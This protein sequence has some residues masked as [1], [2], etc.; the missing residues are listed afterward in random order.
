MGDMSNPHT[1]AVETDNALA[2]LYGRIEQSLVK[3][4]W[5][6]DTIR[7]AAGQERVSTSRTRG[8]WAVSRKDR[9]VA[10]LADALTT[11]A[12]LLI[13]NAD[14]SDYAMPFTGSGLNLGQVRR[15][16][17]TRDQLQAEVAE[18]SVQIKALEEVWRTNGR[19]SRFFLVTSSAGH[20]H[21]SMNCSTCRPTTSFG[22]LPDVSGLT[23]VE[24]VEAH[25]PTLCS[26]CFPSAP[27]E[28]TLTNAQAKKLAK[29]G[30]K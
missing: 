10:K 12:A 17:A 15:A 23:E 25:G 26:V 24:A 7:R 11:V 19:W 9:T 16:V 13:E 28:W 29:N 21:S 27:V 18:I 4:G 5:H 14:D 6:E 8:Y 3:I 1:L 30:G 20:I 2:D 22:W